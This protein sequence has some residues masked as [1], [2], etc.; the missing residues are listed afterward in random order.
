[1]ITKGLRARIGAACGVAAAFALAGCSGPPPVMPADDVAAVV[2]DPAST[3]EQVVTAYIAALQH[4]DADAAHALVAPGA[5]GVADTWLDDTPEIRD[6]TV[7]PAVAQD[8]TGSPAAE[9]RSSLYVPVQFTL[10]GGDGSMQEGRNG[11][12]Y[13]L[14]RNADTEPWRIV[15]DG[16]G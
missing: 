13:L 12:G 7:S 1:M 9:Y 10:H 4:H 11:W 16:V 3:P 8:P 5:E 2:A 6:V 15:D 14:V